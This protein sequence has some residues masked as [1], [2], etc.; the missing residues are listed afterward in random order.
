MNNLFRTLLTVS[1][2]WLLLPKQFA[3][4]VTRGSSYKVNMRVGL[5]GQSP[6]SINTF[7]RSGKKTS[8]SQFSDDGQVETLVEFSAKKSLVNEKEGIYMDVLVTKR[9]RGQSKVTERAKIFAPENQ[10]MEFGTNSKGKMQKNLSLAVMAYK[11]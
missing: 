9:V 10:E 8:I 6:F 7:A 5:K 11:L 3:A 1:V 2:L 4:A